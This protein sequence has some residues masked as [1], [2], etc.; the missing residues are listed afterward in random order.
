MTMRAGDKYPAPEKQ[1]R[2]KWCLLKC[3]L[4]QQQQPECP[5]K[6]QQLEL[7]LQQAQSA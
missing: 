5:L 4:K 2:A 7:Q 3:P 1:S 6:Q